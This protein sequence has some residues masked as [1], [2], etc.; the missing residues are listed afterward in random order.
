MINKERIKVQVAKA[1]S[2]DPS[3][4][5][6]KRQGVNAF[7]EPQGEFDVTKITGFF[8]NGS[9][10][11]NINVTTGASTIT[12]RNEKFIVVYDTEGQKI[13]ENDYFILN[14]IKYKITDLGNLFDICLDM[15]LERV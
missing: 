12:G 13:K 2:Q 11:L 7:N 8:Y 6:V 15:T 9:Q 14:G 5:D 1:I 10:S 3:V 4:V